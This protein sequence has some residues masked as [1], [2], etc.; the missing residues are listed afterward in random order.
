MMSPGFLPRSAGTGEGLL[1]LGELGVAG[2]A[3]SG[4]EETTTSAGTLAG[5]LAGRLAGGLNSLGGE[6]VEGGAPHSRSTT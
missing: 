1:S 3:G 4:E 5:R 2:P 6:V